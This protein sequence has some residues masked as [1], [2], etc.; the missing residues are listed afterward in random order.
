MR[1][2]YTSH[3]SCHVGSRPTELFIV[4]WGACSFSPTSHLDSFLNLNPVIP[5]KS[6]CIPSLDWLRFSSSML[7]NTLCIYLYLSNVIVHI[8]VLFPKQSLCCL[9]EKPII[10]THTYIK[11]Q[12]SKIFLTLHFCF[13]FKLTYTTMPY[14][15]D[16]VSMFWYLAQ[17]LAHR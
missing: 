12:H 1:T 15:I 5:R 16:S 14:L 4:A 8:F 2:D 7:V 6:C 13:I 3:S 17:S 9:R 10:Y 11:N